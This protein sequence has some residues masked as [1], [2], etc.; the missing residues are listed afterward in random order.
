MMDADA[1]RLA[2]DR[3]RKELMELRRQVP[4]EY[5]DAAAQSVWKT[6]QALPAY[7]AAKNVSAMASFKGEIEAF[8]ILD[9]TLKAGKRLFR[10]RVSEDRS[11]ITFHEV[12]DLKDLVPGTFG[13]LEPP[14]GKPLP[15]EKLDLVLMPGLAFS[16]RG[17]RLG[18]G[19]GYYDQVIPRLREGA[20]A[21][22]LCF[23]FQ[24]LDPVPCAPHDVPVHALLTEKGFTTCK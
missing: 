6:L 14:P 15:P 7:L 1:I 18:F 24:V 20:L 9:G 8:P 12:T 17:Q 2:K 3:M 4:Q 10:P 13:I 22:G 11:G 23:S 16:P 19:A 21:V 5:S